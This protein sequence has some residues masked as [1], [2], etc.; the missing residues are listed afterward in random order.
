[1][2]WVCCCITSVAGEVGL[3]AMLLGLA[4]I[5]IAG[6]ISIAAMPIEISLNLFIRV[7]WFKLFFL[8]DKIVTL[9]YCRDLQD[10]TIVVAV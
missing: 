7:S 10:N 5:L 3:P 2:I 8:L 6:T 9:L 1:M 4:F